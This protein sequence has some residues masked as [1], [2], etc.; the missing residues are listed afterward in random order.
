M[1]ANYGSHSWMTL[2]NYVYSF[3]KLTY[4]MLTQE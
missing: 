1:P 3:Q 4:L 2:P